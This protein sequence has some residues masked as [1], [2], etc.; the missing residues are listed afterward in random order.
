MLRTPI[1]QGRFYDNSAEE[2]DNHVRQLLDPT[3]SPAP[4]LGCIVPH[5]GYMYSGELAGKTLSRCTIPKTVLLLGPNHTGQGN[6]V[7]ISASSWQLPTGIVE[8][9]I[10]QIER[11][12]K[13]APFFIVDEAAHTNEHS[14]E[15]QLPFLQVLQPDLHIIPITLSRLSIQDCILV[16]SLLAQFI[17]ESPEEIF[18]L[19]SNDMSHF[20]NRQHT[21]AVD[22]SAL[23][24][25][26][27]MN[28]EGLYHEIIGNNIS[29]CG[30]VPVTVGLHSAKILGASSVE[31]IDYYD[32]GKVSGDTSS[33][34]GYAGLTIQ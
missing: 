17:N 19:I 22:K 24:H 10:D 8:P 11:L 16:G 21:S 4:H 15:V 29:M 31:L 3:C 27:Q 14:L 2:L 12:Q 28:P 34:V 5:A 26:L 7:S 30:V 13:L 1:A 33:V 25:I 9:A 18:I 32:S 20:E 23:Q 6:P